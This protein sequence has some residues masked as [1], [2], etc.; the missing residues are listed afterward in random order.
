MKQCFLQIKY[1]LV[2]TFLYLKNR[3]VKS[4]YLLFEIL[5]KSDRKCVYIQMDSHPP[6][7]FKKFILENWFLNHHQTQWT[8]AL[9][10]THRDKMGSHR[11]DK[12]DMRIPKRNRHTSIYFYSLRSLC[13]CWWWYGEE[14]L[15]EL[16]TR[17]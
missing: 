11:T 15:R 3:V 6:H 17:C 13:C 12:S 10:R 5:P 16:F 7:I 4:I 2:F 1:L 14:S 8:A 9:L